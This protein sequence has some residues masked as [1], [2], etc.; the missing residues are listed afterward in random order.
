MCCSQ[1]DVGT[2]TE[3]PLLCRHARAQ[4]WCRGTCSEHQYPE[5]LQKSPGDIPKLRAALIPGG[6][7]GWIQNPN[8]CLTVFLKHERITYAKMGHLK[9]K[10]DAATCILPP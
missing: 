8:F 6:A 10:A 2:G 3:Q 5:V 9:R 4:M 7:W 1:Q